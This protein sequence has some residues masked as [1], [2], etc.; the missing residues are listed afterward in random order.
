MSV[1]VFIGEAL[2]FLHVHRRWVLLG[3]LFGLSFALSAAI[4]PMA[5]RI[6]DNSLSRMT[7]DTH[8]GFAA[9]ESHSQ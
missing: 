3:M 1:R 5:P 4:I 2:A 7:T 8:G 6:S 9:P